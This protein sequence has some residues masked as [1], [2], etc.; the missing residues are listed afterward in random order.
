MRNRIWSAELSDKEWDNITNKQLDELQNDLAD[1]WEQLKEEVLE[2][3]ETK[4]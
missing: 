4:Q 2:N 3:G 1:F